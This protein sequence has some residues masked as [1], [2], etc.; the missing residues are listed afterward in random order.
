MSDSAAQPTFLFHDYETFGKSPS[1][2]RPAQF[3]ALRTDENFNVIGEPEVFYCKPAD[4][5]LPQPEAVLIT[6]ITPQ[7][8]LARGENE[9]EFARRIHAL[10]TVPK[11][12]V[13]GYN[14]VRFDDEVTRNI[15]YRNFYD[16]YAWSWQHDNSRWDLLDV[17]RACYALRPEGIVWPENSD[18]LP[19]FRLEHL[20]VANGIEHANA[21]DAMA[22]VHATIAMAQ[23]VK[24]RQPR[25]FDYLYTYRSKQKLA[26]L[27]DI[28]QMKP[29]VH[30]SGMFGAWRGN[31]S[32]IAPIAWHPD[33]RNAV[34]VVDLAG[35][36]SPL[37]ELDAD[38]LR[39]RLYTPKAALGDDSAV[40]VKLVHLNKCP[41]LAQANTL[42]P[43]DAERL[44]IDRQHCLNNLK[45]LRDA[46]QVR[47][48]LVALFAE[49]PPF[50][51][52][53]NVDAQLYDGFFSD[54][55]RAAMR[56][57]LQTPPQNL[58]ALDITF[59]DKRIEKLLFNYR[60]RNFPGT[61]SEPEQQRWLNH[62]R[63]VFTPE[64]LQAYAQELEML[65][66]QYESD[67][68]KTALLKA[69]YQYAQ[70]MVG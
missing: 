67:K 35:D 13:V 66:N 39:E 30:V 32:W 11:T 50:P 27:I 8:A 34:I 60:A 20:T 46:P 42:R 33:N 70:E 47:E 6:G 17:M 43:E 41:V 14:N 19:S 1:L 57:V 53:S 59:V 63:D 23:L 44:G 51:P 7:V 25:M 31:T 9:A 37:L 65:Y 55:D 22:D 45:V 62:R 58:P 4:D 2:D 29:L 52:T 16:P 69:L 21:H 40:P 10:F 56:I 38:A 26:T 36:I 5:Y 24:T 15:F 12:C 48:K 61:L 54:A 49:A 3:A 18:G 68:E 28:V 64:F